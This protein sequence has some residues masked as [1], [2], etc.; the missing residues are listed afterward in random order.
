MIIVSECI[1][2]WSSAEWVKPFILEGN[3]KTM[4]FITMR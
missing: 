1:L 3:G 4:Q 2:L